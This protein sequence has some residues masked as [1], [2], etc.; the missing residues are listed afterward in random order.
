LIIKTVLLS[1][2]C[3]LTDDELM[4][5]NTTISNPTN[6]QIKQE[7]SLISLTESDEDEVFSNSSII[8]LKQYK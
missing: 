6:R 2:N 1:P 4:L 3:L 7:K 8:A 5:L